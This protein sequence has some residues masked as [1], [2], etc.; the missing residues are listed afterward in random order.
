MLSTSHQLWQMLLT[1]K[2]LALSISNSNLAYQSE[3]EQQALIPKT[4]GSIHCCFPISAFQV[5]GSFVLSVTERSLRTLPFI[6][7]LLHSLLWKWKIG[8]QAWV[9]EEELGDHGAGTS[10]LSGLN[11]ASLYPPQRSP[12]PNYTPDTSTLLHLHSFLT[13]PPHLT[14]QFPALIM[15]LPLLCSKLQRAGEYQAAGGFCVTVCCLN[16]LQE[17]I[18]SSID[19]RSLLFSHVTV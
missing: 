8:P 9:C 17:C 12:H 4:G 13:A 16:S 14:I 3:A 19:K 11:K 5:M 6:P 18:S 2:S 7:L 1:S 15:A 10:N